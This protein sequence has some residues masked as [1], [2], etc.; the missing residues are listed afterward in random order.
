[1]GV[2][3]ILGACLQ[4]RRPKK[5]IGRWTSMSFWG[6]CRGPKK[7]HRK[8]CWMAMGSGCP[9]MAIGVAVTMHRDTSA[10]H[11]LRHSNIFKSRSDQIVRGR[12]ARGPPP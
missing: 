1:M 9:P 10:V 3:R 8:L 5:P 12:G 11:L 6:A 4:S 2:P 7:P